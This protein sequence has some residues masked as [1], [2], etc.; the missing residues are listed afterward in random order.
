M[1]YPP[2]PPAGETPGTPQPDQPLAPPPSYPSPGY[3]PPSMPY[4]PQPAYP[5]PSEAYPPPGYPQPSMPY[6]PQPGYPQPS[7]PYMPQPGYA[8]P[9]MPYMP[10]PGY[11]PTGQPFPVPG[12]P[13][14]GMP[15]MVPPGY[16]FPV[17]APPAPTTNG[18]A[19]TAMILG[20]AS[21]VL[22][23]VPFLSVIGGGLAI[24]FGT[25]T[26]NKLK[27]LPFPPGGNRGMALAGLITGIIGAALGA[28]IFIVNLSLYFSHTP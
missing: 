9:S 8:P 11:P 2:L 22:F 19:V 23:C 27:Q 14:P 16:S 21:V 5:Q 26:L 24:T 17:M 1:D 10:Q 25:I 12:Y 7:M 6:P 3:A 4:P 13:P 15:F 18:M 20:I 28:L